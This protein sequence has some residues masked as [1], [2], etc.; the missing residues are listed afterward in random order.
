MKKKVGLCLVLMLLLSGCGKDSFVPQEGEVGESIT[1]ESL[2]T[3]SG[4]TDKFYGEDSPY[5]NLCLLLPVQY[6]FRFQD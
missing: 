6:P 1:L 5:C 3:L 2:L 4:D